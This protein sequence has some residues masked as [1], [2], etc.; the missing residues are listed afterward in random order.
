MPLLSGDYHPS[1]DINYNANTNIGYGGYGG[2]GGY[3]GNYNQN[4]NS[5]GNTKGH[6]SKNSNNLLIYWY[7]NYINYSINWF[8]ISNF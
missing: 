4:I 3:S 6:G 1:S 5:N 2:H 8:L 7:S